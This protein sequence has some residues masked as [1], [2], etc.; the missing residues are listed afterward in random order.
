MRFVVLRDVGMLFMVAQILWARGRTA[1][2]AP[3]AS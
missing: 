2:G 3:A 1:A